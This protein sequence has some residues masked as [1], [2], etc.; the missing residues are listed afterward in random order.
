MVWFYETPKFGPVIAAVRCECPPHSCAEL[1][2]PPSVCVNRL[3]GE[4]VTRH[5]ESCD[6]GGSSMQWHQDGRCLRCGQTK[7]K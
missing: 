5:C 6:P 7:D 2:E 3:D 4:V 1:C